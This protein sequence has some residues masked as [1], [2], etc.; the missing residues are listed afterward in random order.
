MLHAAD[1]L[2]ALVHPSH[3]VI[4]APGAS[5]TCRVIRPF[6][7]T[8]PGPAQA[9]FKTQCVLSCNANHLAE[10]S[11]GCQLAALL[12]RRITKMTEAMK[13]TLSTQPADA[14]W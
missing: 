7:L 5:L 4:Y 6:G 2:A 10:K 3:I 8:P 13:I 1:A 14:R 9:L 12:Q 11:W